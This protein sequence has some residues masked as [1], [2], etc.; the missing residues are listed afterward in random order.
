MSG[1][2]FGIVGCG[3]ISEFHAQAIAAIP[4]A[5]LVA[6]YDAV[7]ER[8]EALAA[9]HGARAYRS[10]GAFLK[11]PNLEIVTIGTPSGAHAEP[12][13]RA[14]RAGKHLIVEKPLDVTLRRCDRIIAA[15]AGAGVKLATV[16]PS[17]FAE[18]SALAKQAVAAGRFGRLALGSAYIKWWRTQAY[19]DSGAW[20][21][22][23][24]LDGGG[25]L[26]NQS[27][28]AIDLLQ[29]LMGP[30][31]SVV[32][33]AGCLAHERIEV[34]D[35]AAAVLGFASGAL[36][37]IEGSTA[38]FPGQHKRIELCG[39][40]GSAIVEDEAIR[41]WQFAPE[42]PEDA[43]VRARFAEGTA[44]GGHSDPKAINFAGHQKQFEDFIRALETGSAPLVDC[45][46]GRKSVEIILAIYKSARAGGRPVKLPLTAP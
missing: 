23:W 37:V 16:F 8:A 3:M 2:G 12:A 41:Q 7:A 9:K 44:A 28:H 20:R 45:P 46:E 22:T 19:Y 36:G 27:I 29:W 10:L 21:G 31:E 39:S 15:C 30:V 18:S 5:K 14:A 26:M 38:A 43:A 42:Q 1:H 32:A 17:R 35:T 6:A 25:A 33:R 40:A 24:K 4:G 11:A 34:E 13:V